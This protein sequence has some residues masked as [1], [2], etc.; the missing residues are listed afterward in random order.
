MKV[1]ANYINRAKYTQKDA[2]WIILVIDKGK[3]NKKVVKIFNSYNWVQILFLLF[4]NAVLQQDKRGEI[5]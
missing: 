3:L 2:I 4:L 5:L 1:Y